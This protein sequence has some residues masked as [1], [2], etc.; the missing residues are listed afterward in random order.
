MGVVVVDMSCGCGW[1]RGVVNEHLLEK[2]AHLPEKTAPLTTFP[3][4]PSQLK[5]NY[6]ETQ[7]SYSKRQHTCKNTA[8]LPCLKYLDSVK[9]AS[10]SIYIYTYISSNL[11][12]LN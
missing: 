3:K 12:K 2:T 11:P 4:V 10:A 8:S 7:H 6:G 5:D 1:L 9:G